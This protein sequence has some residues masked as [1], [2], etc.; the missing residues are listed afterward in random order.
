MGIMSLEFLFFV[1]IVLAAYY[2]VPPRL[3]WTVLLVSGLIF[4][5][6][7]TPLGLV[8]LLLS[9][10]VAYV[11]AL[12]IQSIRSAL[13]F[14]LLERAGELNRDKKKALRAAASK[15]QNIFV[16]ISVCFI[17]GVLF[18]CKYYGD[19]AVTVNNAFDLK[20]KESIGLILPLGI[21]YYSL[22]LISYVCDVSRGIT[23]AEKNPL[24]LLL[25]SSFFLTIMQ[26]PFVR[27]GNIMPQIC[28]ENRAAPERKT[29]AKAIF[30][31][32]IGFIKKLC[33]ADQF[34]VFVNEIFRNSDYYAGAVIAFGILCF[35]VQLYA[36]FSGYMDIMIGIG[37][38]LGL[39]LPENFDRPFFS[40][41]ISE[42]WRRW[43]I[44]LGKWLQDYVFYPLLKS[45]PFKALGS[46]IS[47]LLGK[48]AG[49]KIPVYCGMLILW[50]TIG[51]WHGSGLNY[52]FGV[53]ILQFIFILIGELLEPLSRFFT[54]KCKGRVSALFLDGFRALRTAALMLFSWVFFR[55]SGFREALH[56]LSRL[57]N[58]EYPGAHKLAWLFEYE[59]SLVSGRNMYVWL[60]YLFV[61]LLL[62][63]LGDFLRAKRIDIRDRVVEAGYL[64]RLLIFLT[65]IFSIII[66]GAYGGDYNSSGFIYF[67]F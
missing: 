4:F 67:D 18:G 9:V 33:I 40:R 66:F 22:Q 10:A 25:Y 44:T 27:Y 21:S 65:C 19:F 54:E 46:F 11:C 39:S 35:G 43:H 12:R 8:H 36:D 48:S 2:L 61:C 42:F 34:A 30:R 52:V 58:R 62:L 60:L 17:V 28:V 23:D 45:E 13:A 29:A 37:E 38:L 64:P 53:G 6:S 7:F 14:E 59:S 1:A 32:L 16:A 49:R 3:S 5:S 24:K 56:F 55:A 47:G 20:F 51:L 63:L 15:R 50:T 57:F 26:G 41:T 31:I